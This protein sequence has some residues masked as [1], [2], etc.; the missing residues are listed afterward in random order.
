MWEP[1]TVSLLI[2]SLSK[3]EKTFELNANHRV[4]SALKG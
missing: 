1:L 3:R 2:E 4:P